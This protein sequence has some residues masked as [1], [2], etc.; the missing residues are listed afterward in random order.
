MDTIPSGVAIIVML[1]IYRIASGS[2][3]SEL[4]KEFQ[5]PTS[6]LSRWM[7]E[8]RIV[9]MHYRIRLAARLVRKFGSLIIFSLPTWVS[10]DDRREIIRR[11]SQSY[12]EYL[13]HVPKRILPHYSSSNREIS[14]AEILHPLFLKEPE[15]APSLLEAPTGQGGG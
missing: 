7:S 3:L 6:T 15:S 4:A 11:Y 5:L 10:P 2:S 14:L 1:E 13:R 8:Q 12:R 9:N